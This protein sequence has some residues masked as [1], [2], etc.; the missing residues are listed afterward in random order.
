MAGLWETMQWLGLGGVVILSLCKGLS[1]RH[2]ILAAIGTE[3]VW[4]IGALL[5][6]PSSAQ[7]VGTLI[8]TA[9]V[10]AALW[11]WGR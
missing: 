2:T 1:F 8:G 4:G 9:I 10:F 5:F 3:F 6:L 11:K 7:G